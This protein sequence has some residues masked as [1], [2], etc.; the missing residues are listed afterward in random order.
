MPSPAALLLLTLKLR[1]LLSDA[2]DS[3]LQAPK[4]EEEGNSSRKTNVKEPRERAGEGRRGQGRTGQERAGQGR[5]GR[6]H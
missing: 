4:K 6:I 2:R 5:T 3:P 1:T